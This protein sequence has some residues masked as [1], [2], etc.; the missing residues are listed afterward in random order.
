MDLSFD[1]F[2]E[3]VWGY[4]P[5]PWQSALARRVAERGWPDTLDLPTGSG[6]TAVLD[7]ALHHLI[8]DGGRT[9]PRRILMVVD[10]RVVVDQVAKRAAGL[11]E[12]IEKAE[13]PALAAARAALR[14][15]VGEGAPLLDAPVL[16]G[17]VL[18]DDSWARYPHVP[19]LAASTV[20]QVGSR[21]LFRG[22]G[23]SRRAWPIHAGLMGCDTLFLLDEVHLSRPFADLLGQLNAVRVRDSLVPR[24]TGV[25]KLSATPGAVGEGEDRFGLTH[26]DR[27]RL[28]SI[29]TAPKPSTL[30]TV[31]VRA[32]AA[33]AS[34]RAVLAASAANRAREMVEEGRKAVLV[35]VNRVDTARRVWGELG[36]AENFDRVLLT[37]RMRPLDRDAVLENIE[38][39]VK[40]GR[41]KDTQARPLVLVSTQSIEAGADFD[42]D[43]LVT[44]C[45]SLDALRQRFGRL[46]RRGAIE[47]RI[48][49]KARAV[50]LAR[51]DLDDTDPVYGGAAK[52][53]WEWLCGLDEV[54]FGIASLTP[55]LDAI[56]PEI[57]DSMIAPSRETAVVLPTYLE[58]WAQTNPLPQ[59]DPDVSLFLHGIPPDGRSATADVRVIWRADITEEDLLGASGDAEVLRDL[60]QRVT[61]VPPA[62]LEALSLP[63]WTVRRWLAREEE[64]DEPD[65]LSDAEGPTMGEEPP[66]QKSSAVLDWRGVHD[67]MAVPASTIRPGT[68]I[69]LPAEYGGLPEHGTFDPAARGTVADLGDTAQLLQRGRPTLRLDERVWPLWRTRGLGQLRAELADETADAKERIR[70]LLVDARMDEPADPAEERFER[71]RASI[72]PDFRL[73]QRTAAW[74]EEG[75]ETAREKEVW[76][77][78][79][80]VR[81]READDQ[82]DRELLVSEEDDESFL[83]QG[84]P[85]QQHCGDVADTAAEFG[86]LLGLPVGLQATLKWAG[87][88]HDVGKVDPRFLAMLHGGDL[89]AAKFTQPVAKSILPAQDA[90]ARAR[91]RS[92]AGYPAGQRHE[93][94]SLDM[95]EKSE[96]LRAA[97]QAEGAEWDLVLYLV[98]S[99]HGWG[100]PFAPVVRGETVDDT[101]EWTVGGIC[102]EGTT[103]H[104]RELLDSGVSRRFFA[105]GRRYGWHDVAYLEAILRLA[106]HRVSQR[107]EEER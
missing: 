77:A 65:D 41:T 71:L 105:L 73:V 20:D 107:E 86:K 54:D 59:A 10:R 62:S 104:R 5:H 82:G 6:K 22:Y 7:I 15:M 40:A 75:E 47:N 74:A 92:L 8:V 17:G 67:T 102:I 52:A 83:Q 27:E 18:R 94:V 28:A 95:I 42:F 88:L 24:R 85:L 51:N 61:A 39:R 49:V 29:L 55:H 33:E 4:P 43:G 90:K 1:H 2:F 81:R 79:G 53:T 91:A 56:P 97:V 64:W 14:A 31:T 37:G 58:Q 13:T 48:G 32:R 35:V 11:R 78:L 44:E 57:L 87:L 66:A 106:D 16:R 26:E 68:T 69:V 9:A 72:L 30:D 100:R 103:R 45:A 99:H 34:K 101:V 84:V 80:R 19:V 38:P 96:A 63:V 70:S 12:K 36:A 98:G 3:E 93:M 50:I 46:D 25:V 89:I 21:L 60:V 76:A 23:V